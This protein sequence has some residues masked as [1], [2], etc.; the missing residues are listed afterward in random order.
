MLQDTIT[1]DSLHVKNL[2]RRYEHYLQANRDWLFRNAPR[3]K[4]NE[5]IFEAVHHFNLSM[6]IMQFLQSYDSGVTPEFPT[7]NGKLDLLIDHAGQI[8]GLEV[9][10]FLNQREYHKSLGQA[11]RYAR[12]L[13]LTEI[14]L[15]LFVERVD[16]ANRQKFEVTYT[17]EETGITVIPILVATGT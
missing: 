9:K 8:Y 12:Q 16:D 15:I 6:Y 13:K 7:G 5:R 4:T 10:S 14:A 1:A 3:R 2:M 17:D 11:A